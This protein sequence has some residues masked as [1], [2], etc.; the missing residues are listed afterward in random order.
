M[1]LYQEWMTDYEYFGDDYPNNVLLDDAKRRFEMQKQSLEGKNALIDGISERIVVQNHTNPL[2]QSKYDK[3]L[4][5]D[6]ESKV[7]T[8]SIV[9]FDNKKWLVV[10]K[11]FDKQAYKVGSV[12]ECINTIQ[13]NK[14]GILYDIPYVVFDNT[15]LTRMGTESTK[16]FDVPQS[17]MMIMI[18]DNSI[19]RQINRSDVFTLYDKDG[20]KDNY[21]ILDINRA[22]VPGLIIFELQWSA[23]N[24]EIPTYSISITNGTDIQLTLA[25]TLQ[26]NVQV[27]KDDEL[28]S[29][30]PS[31]II[32]KSSDNSIAE[33]DNTGLIQ[34]INEGDA[35]ITVKYGDLSTN[36]NISVVD[37]AENNYIARI[38]NSPTSIVKGWSENFIG[39]FY[40]NGIDIN[41]EETHF[42]LT[43][44]DGVSDTT[45]ATITYQDTNGNCT[46]LA[47]NKTGYVKLWFKNTD[48]SIVSEPYRIKICNI[49]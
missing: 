22:R 24:Q 33:V 44:D 4:S 6:I 17:R 7:R 43:A 13:L 45:L 47:G 37:D 20:V 8:G 26:L 9:E 14:D 16:F 30:T 48:E 32:Y 11:I 46:I 34:S 40:N 1:K 49:Y 15:A 3:K 18:Q 12:L 28:I 39:K 31:Q 38:V 10:S 2:N 23:E 29:P 25:H 19:N 41:T 21:E 36:I 35:I 5:F 27:Y 42:Y